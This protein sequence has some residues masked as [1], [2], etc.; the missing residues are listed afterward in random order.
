VKVRREREI[1]REV[2][3]DRG[4]IVDA[5]DNDGVSCEVWQIGICGHRSKRRE[6]PGWGGGVDALTLSLARASVQDVHS[7][8]NFR[9]GFERAGSKDAGQVHGVIS[10][11]V[12]CRA[13]HS[14]D[15]IGGAVKFFFLA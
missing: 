3:H 13:F 15:P 11:G 8:R 9:E 5:P 1:A 10:W 4:V 2:R 7:E 12:V 14:I 6:K